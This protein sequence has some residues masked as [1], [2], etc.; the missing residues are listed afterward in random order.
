VTPAI[1]TTGLS[2]HCLRTPRCPRTCSTC[3][4]SLAGETAHLPLYRT[5]IYCAGCCP[6]CKPPETGKSTRTIRTDNDRGEGRM[7]GAK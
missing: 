3:H 2:A 1:R 5:G 6:A 4:R 7:S